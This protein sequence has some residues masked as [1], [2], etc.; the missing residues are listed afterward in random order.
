MTTDHVSVTVAKMFHGYVLGEQV[1][2]AL[3]VGDVF[4]GAFHWAEQN[5]LKRDTPEWDCFV[6]AFV[7]TIKPWDI[8]SDDTGRIS[9]LEK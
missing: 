2:N 8:Y 7:N 3:E 1:A 9:K 5:N 6:Q 4:G